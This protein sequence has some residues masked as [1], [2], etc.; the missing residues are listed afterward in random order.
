MA[1]N[2]LGCAKICDEA[3]AP[4]RPGSHDCGWYQAHSTASESRFNFLSVINSSRRSCGRKDRYPK[5][6]G[7]TNSSDQRC[8]NGKK[9]P[10]LFLSRYFF[11]LQVILFRFYTILVCR[12]PG[13]FLPVPSLEKW[14]CNCFRVGECRTLLTTGMTGL[15]VVPPQG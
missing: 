3:I 5:L 15:F 9:R 11:S 6:S 8:A 10:K 4:P 1:T 12:Y 2:C 7:R 13:L 14:W